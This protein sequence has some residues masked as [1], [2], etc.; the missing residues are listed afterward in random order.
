LAQGVDLD[1]SSRL[2]RALASVYASGKPKQGL[3][4]GTQQQRGAQDGAPECVTKAGGE[5]GKN[6]RKS[7]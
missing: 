3:E 1:A 2:N 5:A 7:T 6:L 4:E